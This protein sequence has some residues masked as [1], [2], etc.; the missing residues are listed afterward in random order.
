VSELAIIILACAL[1]LTLAIVTLSIHTRISTRRA[2]ERAEALARHLLT[3]AELQQLEARGYLDVPSGLIA[4]RVY[5]VPASPGLVTVLEG[6]EPVMRLCLQPTRKLPAREQIL[7]HKLLLEGAEDD[8][9]QRANR[10]S[11]GWWRA[12]SDAQVELW[13]GPPPG[14]LNQPW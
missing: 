8:Y 7:V 3:P 6:G 1:A 4:G 11:R 5:R 10:I 2:E 12:V 9:W 13:T 14:I